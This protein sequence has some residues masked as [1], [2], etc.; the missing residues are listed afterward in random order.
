M[1]A[2]VK[3]LLDAASD[4]FDRHSPGEDGACPV[5]GVDGS[6]CR[7]YRV[8]AEVLAAWAGADRLTGAD[9]RA[10]Q[11]AVRGLAPGES[12]TV[13]A[14]VARQEVARQFAARMNGHAGLAEGEGH[15]P[16][17][18]GAPLCQAE[19]GLGHVG[20]PVQVGYA[21]AMLTAATSASTMIGLVVPDG[22]V[23]GPAEQ[24]EVLGGVLQELCRAAG[25]AG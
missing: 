23:Y 2:L 25:V 22:E 18:D 14:A 6:P 24:G 1:D 15:P 20:R 19:A 4:V 8:A 3:S 16:W 9:F 11:G 5:C 7:P 12:V 17:C 13:P 10:A 21:T